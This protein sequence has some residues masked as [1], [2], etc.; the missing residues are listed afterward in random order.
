MDE[1]LEKSGILNLDGIILDTENS[2]VE[3]VREGLFWGSIDVL[4]SSD[5][6][7]YMHLS[8]FQR[9]CDYYEQRPHA[10]VERTVGNESKLTIYLYNFDHKK[11]I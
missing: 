1:Y 2:K 3:V 5:S 6:E 9:I 7:K 4:P 11:K 8:A 10:D